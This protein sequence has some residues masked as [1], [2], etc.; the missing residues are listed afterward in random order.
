MKP[1]G[2][3][4]TKIADGSDAL[5][6]ADSKQVAFIVAER[7]K[8]ATIVTVNINGSGRQELCSVDLHSINGAEMGINLVR[9]SPSG[10]FI[11]FDYASISGAGVD[12]LELCNTTTKAIQKVERVQGSPLG[13]DWTPDGNYT[14]WQ[15][16]TSD[17]YD[18][19][20]YG[21]PDKNGVDAVLVAKG[22]Y[23][24][25]YSSFLSPRFS[26]DGKT[27]ATIFDNVI[28]FYSTPSQTSLLAGKTINPLATTDQQFTQ[29]AW[30][31]DGNTLAVLFEDN[32][33]KFKLQF[34]SLDSASF[35]TVTKSLDENI[36]SID[37]SRF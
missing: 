32:S 33:R 22:N 18:N 11:A 3:G 29:L 1:D 9:W 21:D 12:T 8:K 17:F 20:Y 14:L 27:I 24:L 19:L 15:S 16:Y 5:I 13:Y 34:Y 30:S 36:I 2:T 26:P 28:T 25:A 7:Y 10:H 37:W 35:G 6:S 23:G 4:K 31:P